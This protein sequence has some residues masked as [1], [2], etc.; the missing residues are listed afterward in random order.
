MI[1]G[2]SKAAQKRYLLTFNIKPKIISSNLLCLPETGVKVMDYE[3]HMKPKE[4]FHNN[5]NP[6]RPTDAH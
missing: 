1:T 5:I 3:K 4:R 6:D 2:N